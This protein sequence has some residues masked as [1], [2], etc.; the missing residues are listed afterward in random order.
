MVNKVRFN[1]LKNLLAVVGKFMV[2]QEKLL[3]FSVLTFFSGY[4]HAQESKVIWGTAAVNLGPASTGAFPQERLLS[5]KSFLTLDKFYRVGGENVPATPTLCRF[6][7]SED[8]LYVVFRCT[9]NNLSFPKPVQKSDWYSQLYSANE[10]DAAFPDKVDLFLSLHVGAPDYYMFTATLDGARYGSRISNPNDIEDADGKSTKH[11]YEKI[12]DFKTTLTRKDR[13]WIAFMIIPWKTIG[14]KPTGPFGLTPVRTRYR[15]SE[16]CSPVAFEFA[17]R[18]APDLFIETHLGEKA[19]VYTTNKT[20][21]RLPSGLLRWQRPARADYPS[22]SV[23]KEIWALQQSLIQPTNEKNL[24]ERLYLLQQWITLMELE[25]FNFGS[26]RGSI[27][28]EDMYPL[29]LRVDINNELLKKKIPAACKLL[30]AYLKKIDAVS[31]R[32]FADGS[33]GNIRHDEWNPIFN[34]KNVEE[35]DD[36]LVLQCATAD[37]NIDLHLSLPKLG[38][39]R[40]YTDQQG[41]FKPEKLLPV[42]LNKYS[43]GYLVETVNGNILIQEKP[44]EILC[45]N[46]ENKLVT[47]IKGENISFRLTQDGKVLAVDF[48]NDLGNDEAVYGFGEKYDHFNENGNVLTLWGMDDWIGITTGFRNETYKPVPVFHSSKG[49]SVFINSSYRLRADIGLSQ[50]GQYRLSQHGPVFDYY[51]WTCPPEKA[52]KSY[53]DLTGKPILPPKWAF[54][55]WIGRT[56][57]MWTGGPLHNPV[58][59][60]QG[61][62]KK[63]ADLDIPHSAIYAEG[64]TANL[65]ETHSFMA[66]RGIK[67]LSWYYSCISLK[68]Q[69][70]LLPWMKEEDLPYLKTN[71]SIPSNNIDYV[72]FSNPNAKELSRRWWKQRLDLGVAGSMVDF[73]DRVPETAVFYDGKKGD[74]MH[75][76]YAYDY[77]KT[78][79]EVFRERRGDDFILFGRAAA[80]G[81]QKFAGQFAGDHRANLIGLQSVLHGI[82]NLS[83]CGFSNW[84]CDLGGFRGTAEPAVYMRYTQ[85]SC[86]SPLMRCHGRTPREP[87]EFGEAAVDNYKYFAWVRENLLDYIYNSATEAAE[88]GIPIIRNMPVAF[89]D[90]KNLTNIDDEYMFGR[91]LLVAPVVT[92]DTSRTIFFPV[93]RWVNLW[94]GEPVAG[95]QSI[96]AD[97]PFNTIPVFMKSGSIIPVR[98]SKDLLFGKS[99]TANQVHALILTA[100]KDKEERSFGNVLGTTGKVSTA[101]NGPILEVEITN[102]PEMLYLLVYAESVSGVKFDGNALP[103]LKGEELSSLPVGWYKDD[104]INRVVIRLPHGMSGK[105]EISRN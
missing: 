90:E 8:T 48:R 9:E 18:P 15:N 5:D 105:I 49:Y 102:L 96:K 14:G 86:F 54:E 71:L 62:V 44:F 6:A 66:A 103:P 95:S 7:Y 65:P 75:N 3:V 68:E 93:D 32:W 63:F 59:E 45:Y 35:K 97:V 92:E 58:A 78:Y 36:V 101:S 94:T 80:P 30:D 79:S 76:F 29:T 1:I 74:E 98:L 61:V 104:R 57:R 26:T 17:E 83:S 81:T 24:G 77:H 85:F 55:P 52:L 34:L 89:P 88:T 28:D 2:Q 38:G 37:K 46:T 72:D 84:G 22:A 50:P 31:G 100:P 25:G 70:K 21:C 20:L 39:F 4:L 51:I 53:T 73:G 16:V 13:E 23:K 41:Y 87:W 91:Y 47:R 27:V 33:A 19:K 60:Q 11:K 67:V 40:L 82:L 10:Q 64:I 12:N 43:K 69:K 56:G 99:M 42:K